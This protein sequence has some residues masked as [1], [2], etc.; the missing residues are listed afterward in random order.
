MLYHILVHVR[1]DSK[2]LNARTYSIQILLCVFFFRQ[3]KLT[4]GDSILGS[5]QF[6]LLPQ[7]PRNFMLIT[8]IV[9]NGYK[10]IIIPHQF[11]F[12]KQT[13]DVNRYNNFCHFRTVHL[14][15]NRPA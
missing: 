14:G 4:Q 10:I 13:V 9:K 15:L 1:K 11:E 5:I 3:A 7:L 12:T 8:K 6:L 2:L